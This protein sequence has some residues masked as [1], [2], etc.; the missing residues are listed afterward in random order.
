MLR[1]TQEQIY[2]SMISLF[3]D[4]QTSEQAQQV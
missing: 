4:L 3:I 1:A 2:N